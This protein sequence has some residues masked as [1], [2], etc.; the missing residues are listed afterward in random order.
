MAQ[1]FKDSLMRMTRIS[2]LCEWF[3][4]NIRVIRPFAKFAF[5]IF[6]CSIILSACGPK[7]TTPQPTLFPPTDIPLTLESGEVILLSME[8]N[9]YAHFFLYTPDG[10][11]ILRLTDG[12]W[13]DIAP[14]LSPDG[15]QIAFASNRSGYWDI[16][17][18]TLATA[19]IRQITNTPAY[20]SAPSW[21]PD[22]QWL[23]Y[24]TYD[25]NDLEIAAIQLTAAD[26][27]PIFLTDDPAA[28]TSPAWSPQGRK[29]AFVSNRSGDP[30]VWLADL[31]RPDEGRF[32][33]LSN[34]SF[35]AERRPLWAGNQLL[36]IAE[37]QGVNVS[38][39]FVWDVDQPQRPARWIADADWA[40]WSPSDEK[41]ATVLNGPNVDYFSASSLDG[42]LPLPPRPLPGLVRGLLW[43][44][45]DLPTTPDAYRAA[46]AMT[47]PALWSPA[48]TPLAE[49]PTQRQRLVALPEV[50]APYPQL[51]DQVDEA[52]A[53]LRQRAVTEAGWDALASLQNAFVP[54]TSPLDPGLGDDWLYTGRAFALNSLLGNAGWMVSVREEIGQQT[55]WRIYIRAQNQD[56]SQGL[57]LR[58]APWDLSARYNLDPQAYD[59]GGEFAPIP[60]GYWVDF[61]ALARAYGWER[62]PS[63]PNWRSYF[64]G[65][66]FTE[67]ILTGGL[68]WYSALLEIYPP[69]ALVTPTPRLPPTLTPTLTP[70]PSITS[71]PSPTPSI[72]PSPTFTPV[73]TS[74]NTPIPTPTPMPSN[75]PLP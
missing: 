19:E 58:D 5:Q 20:D 57:P 3:Y 15:K 10:Q 73:P 36:W 31:D 72:T 12:N 38:G 30:D 1:Y 17:L 46:S 26:E 44:T 23:A 51:H 56:G 33:N 2:E 14:S 21:S 59:Q 61:T 22:S 13:S 8:E 29:I 39:A 55:F 24:E 47:P 70:V 9:G 18:L 43:L 4:K 27:P 28:D 62:M 41:L 34:T 63:L 67:F 50:Q 66:R 32:I 11:P 7:S 48:V 6:I 16:Y 37:A 40:A 25:G 45:L 74:T 64:G 42:G 54:L 35:A 68:D 49:G 75:T 69:E 52:F 65:T 60:S 53:A 71:G